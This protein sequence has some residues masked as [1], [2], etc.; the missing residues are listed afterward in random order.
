MG[1]EHEA[2]LGASTVPSSPR[3]I[4]ISPGRRTGSL[5]SMGRSLVRRDND[6]LS[7]HAAYGPIDAEKGTVRNFA[8]S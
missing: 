5:I 4:T 1:N 7:F 3:F 8:F 2:Q 6:D